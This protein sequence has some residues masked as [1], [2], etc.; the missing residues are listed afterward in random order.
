[1]GSLVAIYVFNQSRSQNYS[2]N[3]ITYTKQKIFK[4]SAINVYTYVHLYKNSSEHFAIVHWTSIHS[5]C[6]QHTRVRQLESNFDVK[7]AE[8]SRNTPCV[9]LLVFIIKRLNLLRL[10]GTTQSRRVSKLEELWCK[11][12]EPFWI[13]CR[14]FTHVFFGRHY[15]L[16]VHHPADNKT[17]LTSTECID[18]SF[19]TFC[20]W[21]SI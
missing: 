1:M 7:L 14:H 2:L 4:N 9:R 10:L 3:L 13:N 15:Q 16:V 11:L 21:S 20:T 8:G 12:D 19:F 17:G 5:Y 18:S 6:T